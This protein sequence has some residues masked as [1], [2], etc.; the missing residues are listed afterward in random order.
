MRILL[1]STGR[2]GE[3]AVFTTLVKAYR[4]NLPDAHITVLFADNF[5]NYSLFQNSPDHDGLVTFKFRNK[6]GIVI[7]DPLNSFKQYLAKTKKEFDIQEWASEYDM[8]PAFNSSNTGTIIGNSYKRIKQKFFKLEDV[9]RKIFIYP[10][11]EEL[12][13][14][15]DL[16]TKYGDDLILVSYNTR[17][18]NPMMNEQGYND[19][20]DQMVKH[21]PVA[22]T[23]AAQTRANPSHKNSELKGHID[24]RGITFSAVFAISQQLKCFVGPDTSI[25]WI[26]SNMTGKFI[27]VRGDPTY[28]IS[29][30]GVIA[31]GYRVG[32]ETHEINFIKDHRSTTIIDTILPLIR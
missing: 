13:F 3:L 14:A 15:E 7:K 4:E 8:S 6:H 21:H 26:V 9:Q 19:L 23:G 16:F 18:A 17:S 24:L 5:Q 12:R 30:T 11:D 28:P 27:A 22:Y 2:G 10:T 20:C 25:T 32:K 31:N 29:N 1:G